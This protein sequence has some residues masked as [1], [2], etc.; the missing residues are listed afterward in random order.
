MVKLFNNERG[1]KMIHSICDFCGKDTDRNA[2]LITLTPFQNF[3]RYH[4]D[5]K[6]YG[7]S[8]K[9]KSFVMCSDCL[10]KHELPN[11]FHD[12]HGIDYQR[13]S[14]GKCLDNYSDEDMREDIK[15]AKGLDN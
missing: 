2:T 10:R 9:P 11:P 7:S 15:K 5:T 1:N 13:A 4:S 8:E 12:Y 14:Y 6:P 3:A